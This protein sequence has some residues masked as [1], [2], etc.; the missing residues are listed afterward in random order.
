ME[1]FATS[2]RRLAD[3]MLSSQS[4]VSIPLAIVIAGSGM[5][6]CRARLAE[7]GVFEGKC[8]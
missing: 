4:S 8:N 1:Y 5:H 6:G 3:V 2:G 7:R